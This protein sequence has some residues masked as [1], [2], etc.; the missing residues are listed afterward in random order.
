MAHPKKKRSLKLKKFTK[1]MNYLK[2]KQN[3]EINTIFTK[4]YYQKLRK[5][6]YYTD[7]LRCFLWSILKY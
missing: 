1:N 7:F 6:I 3:K 4:K 5:D 2:L